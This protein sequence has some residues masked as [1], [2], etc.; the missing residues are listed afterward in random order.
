MCIDEGQR[1]EEGICANVWL[2][3]C[4]AVWLFGCLATAPPSI[5]LFFWP[6]RADGQEVGTRTAVIVDLEMSGQ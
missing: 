5:P 3:G 6:R 4:L 1:T 2:F